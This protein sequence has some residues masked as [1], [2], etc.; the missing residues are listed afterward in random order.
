M[1]IAL[2]DFVVSLKNKNSIRSTANTDLP[3]KLDG[4]ESITVIP[5]KEFT[6]NKLSLPK[7]RKLENFIFFI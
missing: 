6:S 3:P 1:S 4:L 2:D 5:P 7:D